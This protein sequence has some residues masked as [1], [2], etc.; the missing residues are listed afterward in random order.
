M[1]PQAGYIA[2]ESNAPLRGL[3]TTP[4]STRLDPA[5][6]PSLWN[7]TVRDGVVRRRAGYTQLGRR[8]VGRV[9]AITEFGDIGDDPWFV[10]FTS[11]RQYVYDPA[12][13][14][15]VDLTPGQVS[16]AII[17]VGASYFTIAGNHTGDFPVDRL[18][19]VIGG[20]NEGVY[21]VVSA[22]LDGTDTVIS[23]AEAVPSLVV[24]G[25]I[26]VADDFDTDDL[27]QMNF[28]ALTDT[29]KHQLLVTNGTET[30]RFWEGDIGVGFADWAPTITS[31]PGFVTCKTFEVFTEHLFLGGIV[32]ASYNPQLVAWSNAGSFEDFDT[33]TSGTQLLYQLNEIKAL[34]VLGD[35]LAIYSEDAVMTGVF[36]DAPAYFGFEL[37]IPEGTRLVSPKS[38]VS[39]NVGHVYL[40]EENV[41]LF[42]GTRG[43]RVLGD[44]IYS[45]YKQRK[46]FENL[47]IITALN[48]YSKRTLYFAVPSVGTE[49]TIY[50]AEYDVF[51]LSRITWAREIYAHSPRAFGFFT[52]RDYEFTWDDAPWEAADTPWSNE[53][54]AWLEETEQLNFPIRAF[55]TGDGDVFLI[56]EGA[57]TDNEIPVEQTYETM[58]FT[59][60]EAFHS[61]YGRWCEVEFEGFGDE[62]T[63]SYS[64]DLGASFTEIDTLDLAP[65]PGYQRVLLDCSSRTIRFRFQSTGYFGLRWIRPW[66]RTGGPR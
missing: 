23:V 57:L 50:T 42:D 33:G 20:D 36:I 55:G 14:D 34:K 63:V 17:E 2:V 8:L 30:P 4:T 6:S 29:N 13:E 24:A 59:V 35:R 66:V 28:V 31:I 56:T 38:I 18:I 61:T 54:G 12:S 7:C 47:H 11:H 1:K 65:S 43:L 48:D 25:V 9:M 10:V 53:L 15:F 60:P 21:T 40:S 3:A 37:V 52:N 58:D 22:I 62:V 27:E 41:Y 46:D 49:S 44:P 45:D 26:V 19:P 39:I 64:T 32:A 51:D 16:Y 5:F